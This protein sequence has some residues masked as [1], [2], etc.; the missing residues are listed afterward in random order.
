MEMMHEHV[1]RPR[2]TMFASGLNHPDYRG[3]MV[4]AVIGA[5]GQSTS[6]QTRGSRCGCGGSRVRWGYQGS[7]AWDQGIGTRRWSSSNQQPV[8]PRFIAP[9][10]AFAVETDST[11]TRTLH[12]PD[13][14]RRR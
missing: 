1:M 4:A 14:Q 5:F 12:A 13:S 7:G 10:T 9:T 6:D 3:V 2:V 8:V 11:Q